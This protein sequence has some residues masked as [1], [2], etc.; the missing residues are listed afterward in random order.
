MRSIAVAFTLLLTLALGAQ[1]LPD[2]G[3][4]T[5]QVQEASK[6]RKSIEYVKQITGE[7]TLDGKPVTE[8]TALGRRIPVQSS[9]GKQ[10]VAL[11]NPGKARIDLQL[12]GGGSLL[13]SDGDT[14]WT[15][16]PS[17]KAYTKVAAAQTAEG[18]A[19][20]LAVL[21]VLGFFA[22]TKTTKT[23]RQES[24]TIDGTVYD[25]W[26]L[27]SSVKLPAQAGMGGQVSD[28][29]MTSWV[30]KKL[31]FEVQEEIAY[32]VKV[33]P[34]NGAAPLEY[35]S[36]IIQVAHNLK[37]DQPVDGTL[38]AYTPPA[39]AREQAPQIAGRVD[40][41]GKDAPSFRGVSLDGKVYSS[42]ELKGKPVLLDFWASWC[43]PCIKSM[44]TMEKLYA[45]YRSQGLVVLAIDV[46]EKRETVEK[47]LT[48]KPM[49]YP[50]IMGDEAGIPSAYG[51]TGFPTFVMIGPD[52]K[53]AAHQLGFN[54][55]ALTGIV[56][57]A[58][59]NK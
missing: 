33:A 56:A 46:G 53:V 10:T 21:D 44:P 58:G 15:Y 57:K 28:G 48:T 35:R 40:L 59:I 12:G 19:A 51:V 54:E 2:A 11:H 4:I 41:T 25:C 36:K 24:I 42:E 13:V 50:V 26:V 7:V 39:D 20:N 52:G 38:F 45:D 34:A 6:Q 3:T 5:K 32:T 22:D 49:S 55:P 14:T 43:G 1:D 23:A 37:V 18:T 31:L 17:T 9:I 30:D 27:T 16:R 8:I 29:V 47:F